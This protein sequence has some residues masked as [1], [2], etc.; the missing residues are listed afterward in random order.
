L[1]AGGGG[2][3]AAGA[4]AAIVFSVAALALCRRRLRAPAAR[5]KIRKAASS[6]LQRRPSRF[7]VKNP[8]K[9]KGGFSQ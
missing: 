7:E 3:F 1:S 5:L 2:L 9:V 4:A 6:K 8:L